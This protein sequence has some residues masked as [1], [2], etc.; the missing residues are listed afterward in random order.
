[1]AQI[2]GVGQN[3]RTP[4]ARRATGRPDGGAM[5]HAMTRREALARLD[6]ELASSLVGPDV[7]FTTVDLPAYRALAR[8]FQAQLYPAPDQPV[9]VVTCPGLDGQPATQVRLLRPRNGKAPRGALLF[10]HGGGLVVGDAATLDG[11]NQQLADDTGWLVAAASYRLAPDHIWP[12]A[13][14]DVAAAW[15]WL[16]AQRSELGLSGLPLVVYGMSAGAG[17]A[18]ALC[19]WLR[20]EG[21]DQ[22]DGQLLVYPMLDHRTGR[23][24]PP[25]Q[26]GWIGWTCASNQFG[27][28]SYAGPAGP[29]ADLTD[30]V[31][32]PAHAADLSGLAPAWIGVGTLDLFLDECIAYAGRLAGA[33]V[34]TTLQTYPGAAHGFVRVT[35]AACSRRFQAD[36]LAWLDRLHIGR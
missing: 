3:R 16:T 1:M 8:A 12:A 36:T 22:P 29:P 11:R 14:L 25:E 34:D 4:A 31:F 6:P 18:A 35:E 26:D 28:T 7:D 13:L 17:L 33:G 15:R 2:I 27:W 9:E 10:V 21:L 24:V 32:A 20:R 5:T 23:G 30:G 19:L